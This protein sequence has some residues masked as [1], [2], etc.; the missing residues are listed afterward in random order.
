MNQLDELLARNRQIKEETRR[1]RQTVRHP[2]YPHHPRKLRAHEGS[3]AG[4][5]SIISLDGEARHFA[6]LEDVR[7]A[8]SSPHEGA[9]YQPVQG[10]VKGIMDR[11]KAG[12]QGW[13]RTL[14][15]KSSAG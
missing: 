2:H 7:L 14:E 8:S 4:D 15:F 13:R 12:H 5:M 1:A 9:P 6:T 10:G 11:I 3:V